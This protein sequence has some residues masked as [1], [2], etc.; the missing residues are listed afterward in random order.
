MSQTT[1]R[2]LDTASVLWEES[3]P[4]G[5]HWSGVLRRGL[6]LRVTD[7]RGGANVSMLFY[8]WENTLERYNMADTLK[9]QHTAFLTAGNVCYTDMGRVICSVTGDTCGWHD[10]ICGVS[11]AATVKARYGVASYQERRNDY[12][13]NGYDS[14]VNELG[15]YGL[16]RRDLVAT[17]NLFS[18][19]TV[20]DDGGMQFHPGN[21]GAGDSVDLRFE[22]DALVV[23][24]TCQHP[25]DP[26]ETYRPRDIALTAWKSGVAGPDDHCRHHCPEN[27][28]AFI[29]TERLY[30]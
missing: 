10:T 8:N 21:S 18:K 24:S 25:L 27:E 5:A 26:D 9:G 16:G 23:L 17:L 4:G 30:A 11:D 14:L 22:M 6:T 13:R 20:N 7:S 2:T 15:K 28:R 19:V 1:P 12:H 3:V 29:N